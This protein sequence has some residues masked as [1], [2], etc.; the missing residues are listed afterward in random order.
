MLEEQCFNPSPS[1]KVQVQATNTLK[2]EMQSPK[3]THSEYVNIL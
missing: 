1:N 2:Q 3:H